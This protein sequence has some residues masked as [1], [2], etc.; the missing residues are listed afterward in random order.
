MQSISSDDT[1][2]TSNTLP[3][4]WT[5]RINT[6]DHAWKLIMR[7]ISIIP[8]PLWKESEKLHFNCQKISIN[9]TL[10]LRNNKRNNRPTYLISNIE[11]YSRYRLLPS[12]P[13]SR[14]IAQYPPRISIDRRFENV[15]DPDSVRLKTVFSPKVLIDN[16]IFLGTK[17]NEKTAWLEASLFKDRTRIAILDSR[18]SRFCRRN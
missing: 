6:F 3:S 15:I 4:V 11:H 2:S 17:L 13:P 9:C 7:K 16:Q 12:N 10:S 5:Y 14:P 1:S 18:L 8:P